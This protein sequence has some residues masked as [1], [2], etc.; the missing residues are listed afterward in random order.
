MTSLRHIDGNLRVLIGIVLTI[1]VVGS[2]LVVGVASTQ[3][4][5]Q[6][7]ET[8]EIKT[9]EPTGERIDQNTVVLDR[10]YIVETGRA[11]LTIRSDTLQSITLTDGGAFIE[12]G[13]I[14]QNSVTLR[15]GETANVS[16][17]AT[18]VQG[19]VGASVATQQT[20]YA[21]PISDLEFSRPPISYQNA[22][23]LVLLAA[24]G[25]A[26]ATWRVVRNRRDDED[27]G[28]ERIL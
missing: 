27:K 14:A 23:L 28:A 16:V 26:G 9:P 15:P 10:K 19:F 17:S 18:K 6:T 7:N 11:V 12:G 5:T 8:V 3:A 24:I 4:Q 1:L 13:E 25:T 21:V 2:L 22:Q 20:L